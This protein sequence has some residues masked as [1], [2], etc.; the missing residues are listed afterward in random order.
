LTLKVFIASD[1]AGFEL[2]EKIIEHFKNDYDF[3]NL[4]PNTDDRVDYPEFAIKLSEK[5][6]SNSLG[7]LVCG[8]GHGVCMTA[9][10]F[11]HI[12]AA[13]CTSEELAKLS[14]A[15]N[16]ANVLCLGSRTVKD[17]LN[18]KIFK[19]FMTTAF[20]GGRH[21]ARVDKMTLACKKEFS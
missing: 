13:L 1:H 9:N 18:L 4:G 20:E 6:D 2:K 15:H 12:R 19:K 3:E 8:S 17:E 11:S 10:K 21:Q 5:I 14:R 16:N 7:V